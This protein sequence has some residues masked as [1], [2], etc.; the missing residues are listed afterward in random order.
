MIPQDDLQQTFDRIWTEIRGANLIAGQARNEGSAHSVS[1]AK[2][3]LQLATESGN[4]GFLVEAWRMLALTL[5][6]NEQYQE[7]VPYY[8]K[9][10]EKLEETGQ[11]SL[12]VRMRIGYVSVLANTAHYRE[13][14]D[15]ARP[16][17]IWLDK[18]PD[19]H[20][21]ARLFINIGIVHARLN[22][23]VKAAEAYSHARKIFEKLADKEGVAR[24]SLNLANVLR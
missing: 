2:R 3:A 21:R 13:A 5:N 6:G 10:I 11:Q 18:N 7:A 16:A 20:A 15:A 9:A 4:D 17:E 19:A 12:A 22:D 24:A 23:H 14:L 1:L 8:G